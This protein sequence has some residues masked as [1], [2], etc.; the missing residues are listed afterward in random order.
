MILEIFYAPETAKRHTH[1][2]FD[3]LAVETVQHNY[4]VTSICGGICSI[5]P[6]NED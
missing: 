3:D 1:S 2:D 4:D 5:M 6:E